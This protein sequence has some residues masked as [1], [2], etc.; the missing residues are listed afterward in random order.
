MARKTKEDAFITRQRII[1]VA[2]SEFSTQGFASTS[3]A[4]IASAAGVTRG[5]IYWHFKNK[6]ELF[7]EIWQQSARYSLYVSEKI[8]SENKD[9]PLKA[10][11]ET[12]TY[13]LRAAVSDPQQKSLM[14]IMFHKCE[15]TK[16]MTPRSEIRRMVYFEEER[17]SNTLKR[18]V[19][20]NQLPSKLNIE[21]SVIIV[22]AYMSGLIENWL[23]CS[24]NYDLNSNASGLV[25][26]LITLLK[27]Q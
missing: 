21:Q 12:L 26:N 11:Q 4:D 13:I 2:I 17:L 5:A 16:E 19:T 9:N 6:E 10:L 7:N 1:N 20:L 8:H 15:F 22:R 24:E 14:K 18:C 23:L 27:I 3:L 25:D